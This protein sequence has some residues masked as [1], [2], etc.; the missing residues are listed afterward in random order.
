MLHAAQREGT[1]YARSFDVSLNK[2]LFTRFQGNG[3]V[4]FNNIY[5]IDPDGTMK[6]G[7]YTTQEETVNITLEYGVTR[8]EMLSCC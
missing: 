3:Q 1:P 5:A 8:R 6:N 4:M 7:L 2:I